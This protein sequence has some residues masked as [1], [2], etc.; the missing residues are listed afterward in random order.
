MKEFFNFVQQN[1]DRLCDLPNKFIDTNMILL[2]QLILCLSVY[3]ATLYLQSVV[4]N[5]CVAAVYPIPSIKK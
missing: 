3:S 4:V 1:A 5:S 2:A